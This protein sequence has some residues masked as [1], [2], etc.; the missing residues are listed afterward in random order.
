MLWIYGHYKW[1]NSFCAGAESD[2]YR[3]QILMYKDGS[4][5]ER[6]NYNKLTYYYSYS[7]SGGCIITSYQLKKHI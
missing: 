1:F 6:V 5:T 7:N 3:R 4:R 2:V